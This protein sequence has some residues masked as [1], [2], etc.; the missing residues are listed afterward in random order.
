MRFHVG[1]KDDLNSFLNWRHVLFQRPVCVIHWKGDLAKALSLSL[2][3]VRCYL[4]FCNR[5]AE[6]G[7][8]WRWS[9]EKEE[10]VAMLTPNKKVV[11]S[12]VG[13]NRAFLCGMTGSP[14]VLQPP[15]TLQVRLIGDYEK[16]SLSVSPLTTLRP[17]WVL[18]SLTLYQR[19]LYLID[20][21]CLFFIVSSWINFYETMSSYRFT[22]LYMILGHHGIHPIK[23][24]H[25]LM[26]PEV[27][28]HGKKYLK[29]EAPPPH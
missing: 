11:G 26:F 8:W 16:L 10:V 1:G 23:G 28:M 4:P 7:C 21:G 15:L 18:S 2:Y 12:T 22:F 3:K 17:A 13:Q 29:C 27:L 19:Q 24:I 20:Y 25:V 5:N 14:S 6:H 9:D